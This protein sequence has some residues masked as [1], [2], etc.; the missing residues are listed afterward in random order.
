[1]RQVPFKYHTRAHGPVYA[2]RVNDDNLAE[3]VTRDDEDVLVAHDDLLPFDP[4]ADGAN[5]ISLLDDEVG[6][7]MSPHMDGASF[8]YAPPRQCTIG[9]RIFSQHVFFNA[10]KGD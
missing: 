3:C 5:D 6:E 2:W 10:V 1:M 8:K 9:E 4:S 7:M